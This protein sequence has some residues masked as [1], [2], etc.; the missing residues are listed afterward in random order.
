[1]L[2]LRT[3]FRETM[4]SVNWLQSSSPENSYRG[5]TRGLIELNFFTQYSWVNGLC[6]GYFQIFPEHSAL[7]QKIKN[8]A[9]FDHSINLKVCQKYPTQ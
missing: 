7:D 6:F 8:Y 1:M 4:Y 2:V 3:S 9:Y 5:P